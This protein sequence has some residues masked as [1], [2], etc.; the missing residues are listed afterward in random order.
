[1]HD[2]NAWLKDA[3]EITNITLVELGHEILISD[4]S[5]SFNNRFTALMGDANYLL[6]RIRLSAP[7]WPIA[8]EEEQF[9]TVVHE[10]CHIVAHHEHY[11]RVGW[12]G[13]IS[14]HGN[15]WKAVMRRAGVPVKRCHHVDRSTVK[16]ALR[17]KFKV[18]CDCKTHW[19]GATRYRRLK[20]GIRTYTCNLCHYQIGT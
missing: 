1:M 5:I 8:S 18:Y 19:F 13:K 10:V 20:A 11:K 4:M 7:L 3:R 9:Q 16:Q 2:Y 17:K 6:R 12:S 14:S 15:E